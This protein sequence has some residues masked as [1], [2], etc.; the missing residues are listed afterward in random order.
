MPN[1]EVRK[2]KNVEISVGECLKVMNTDIVHLFEKVESKEHR[3]A[4]WQN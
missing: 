2:V 3:Y 4:R 1:G